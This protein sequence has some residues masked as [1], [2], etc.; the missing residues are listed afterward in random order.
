MARLVAKGNLHLHRF[1]IARS[2]ENGTSSTVFFGFHT[3]QLSQEIVLVDAPEDILAE[4]AGDALGAVVQNKILPS[5]PT[6]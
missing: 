5:R 6:T 3:V 4:V 2:G 1:A